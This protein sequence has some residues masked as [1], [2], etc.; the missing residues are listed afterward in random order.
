MSYGQDK[1]RSKSKLK[2]VL[3]DRI[4]TMFSGILDFTEV[5]VGDA[6]RYGALRAKVLRL[7]NDTIREI[8]KDLDTD[9]T[10]EFIPKH[11]VV[12]IKKS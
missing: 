5:A 8:E 3:K 4:T 12:V 1:E 7:A 9:Y 11:D 6:G 10:V 2:G